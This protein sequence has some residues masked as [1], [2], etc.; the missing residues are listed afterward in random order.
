MENNESLA[1]DL[2]SRVRIVL[3]ETSHPGNIGAA[4]RAMKNMGI[5]DL[6]LVKPTAF[7]HPDATSRS[8]GAA[9]ILERT[10]VVDSLD[11]ALN[12]CALVFG[13]SARQRRLPWPVLPPSAAAR[14]ALDAGARG[15]G[16]A[17]MFGREDSGLSNDELQ[18]CHYHVQI[19]TTAGFSSLNLAMAVQV[20]VYEIRLYYLCMLEERQNNAHLERMTE[21]MTSPL[22][23]GWDV[24]L[25]SVGEFEQFLQH[26]ET[27]LVEIEFHD[28]ERPRQLLQRLRRLFQRAHPDRMEINILRGVLRNIQKKAAVSDDRF[29]KG[30]TSDG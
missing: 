14:Q 25:A 27:V 3:V 15:A 17:F 6:A 24:P 11:D 30:G 8:S 28:P 1:T 10:R 2:L 13:A 23:P 4:A 7:P 9:D 12:D 29:L 18:R 26:L 21:T 19:P 22:D 20:L 5:S 16:V